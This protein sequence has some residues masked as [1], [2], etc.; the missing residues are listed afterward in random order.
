[1]S[2]LIV[3]DT[4]IIIDPATAGA[5]NAPTARRVEIVGVC[6]RFD[7][8]SMVSET[9]ATHLLTFTNPGLPTDFAISGD[10]HHA[11][12]AY[13]TRHPLQH[14]GASRFD[15]QEALEWVD[16]LP[17]GSRLLVA[18][19][20]GVSRSTALALSIMAAQE[21]KDGDEDQA[22]LD[23]IGRAVDRLL[24][25]RSQA[26]P[27][28]NVLFMAD[29]VMRGRMQGLLIDAWRTVQERA[30]ALIGDSRLIGGQSKA[31]EAPSQAPRDRFRRMRGSVGRLKI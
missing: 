10:R 27:N 28:P 7:I 19:E 11:I 17:E 22:I 31:V 9:R 5:G 8:D 2:S 12:V 24:A 4:R 6:G 1:M 30:P 26:D 15:I 13:D 3:P 21:V 16:A 23:G 18:C 20:M 14:G 29:R 25:L